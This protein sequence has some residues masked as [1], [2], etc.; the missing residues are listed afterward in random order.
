MRWF[1]NHLSYLKRPLHLLA[2]AGLSG[3]LALLTRSRRALWP[4]IILGG[5]SELCQWSFG[6]GFDG[7]DVLD[8]VVD[9]I[10]AFIG[11]GLWRVAL[12][13]WARLPLARRQSATP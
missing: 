2:F 11:L 3:L 4:A 1:F 6:F 7:S 9:T 13:L 8:L 5:V 10:A 12:R